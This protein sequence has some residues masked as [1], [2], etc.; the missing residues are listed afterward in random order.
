MHR[1]THWLLAATLFA[2]AVVAVVTGP[3]WHCLLALMHVPAVLATMLLIRAAVLVLLGRPFGL[4][5]AGRTVLA[6]R[7]GLWLPALALLCWTAL[8]ELGSIRARACAQNSSRD[9]SWQGDPW[10]EVTDLPPSTSAEIQVRAPAGAFGTAFAAQF[11]DHWFSGDWRVAATI[12]VDGEVPMQPWPLYK[13]ATMRSQV[14]AGLQ[15]RPTRGDGP[16][17]SSELRLELGGDF[18]MLGFASQRDFHEW[19]GHDLGRVTRE[20][21]D[22]HIDKGLGKG[23]K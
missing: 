10:H 16:V 7:A 18:R 21:I 20:A 8:R 6:G 19:L 9:L 12:T 1:L 2:V 5:F 13:S 17:R 4:Q 15:L 11:P 3:G 22:K 14:V 23:R